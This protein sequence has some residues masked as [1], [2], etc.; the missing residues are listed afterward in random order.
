MPGAP[1]SGTPRESQTKSQ[2]PDRVGIVEGSCRYR[3]LGV[4]IRENFVLSR[5]LGYKARGVAKWLNVV[6]TPG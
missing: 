3:P 4:C 1:S 6:L 5:N 2:G